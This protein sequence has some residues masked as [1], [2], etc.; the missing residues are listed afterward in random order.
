MGK[1]KTTLFAGILAVLHLRGVE[2]S[3][4]AHER[5]RSCESLDQ[6]VAWLHKAPMAKSTDELFA[7]GD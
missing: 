6:L 4:D 2:I 5:L 1:A 7:E 3:D